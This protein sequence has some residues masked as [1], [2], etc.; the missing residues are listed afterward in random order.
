MADLKSPFRLQLALQGGGAKIVALVAAMKAI[1]DL[2]TDGVIKVTRIAGTSAGA[3]VGALYAARVSMGVV[4]AH[5]ENIDSDKLI[6]KLGK[7]KMFWRF[8]KGKAFWSTDG[9]RE[10]L[11]KLFQKSQTSVTTVG[12]LAKPPGIPMYITAT[13]IKNST[14]NISSDSAPIVNALLDS[15]ALPIVFRAVCSGGDSNILDGGICENLPSDLLQKHIS[16]D[17]PILGFSFKPKPGHTPQNPLEFCKAL[18]DAAINNSM[19]RAKQSLGSSVFNIDTDID[20]F[21]FERALSDGLKAE[22]ENIFLKTKIFIRNFTEQ[23]SKAVMDSTVI[24][25]QKTVEPRFSTISINEAQSTI[26][27][28][29]TDLLETLSSGISGV[30]VLVHDKESVLEWY[31]NLLGMLHDLYSKRQKDVYAAWL[32]PAD[33][34]RP[35]RLKLFRS[36]NLKPDYKHY[37]Y[38]LGEGF[39]GKVWETHTAAAT[40]I[41]KHHPWWVFRKDC[42]NISYICAP[43]GGADGSGGVLAIGSDIGFDIEDSDIVIMKLFASVLGLVVAKEK[44]KLD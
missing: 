40:S 44:N 21:D 24:Q 32:R 31:D 12:D 6:P 38:R 20:T 36:C 1:E 8:L 42:E 19:A 30:D 33:D 18:L 37:E 14:L 4:K 2:E 35:R 28:Y 16:T 3:I 17:G 13:D 27:S 26:L 29:L 34:T 7:W 9:I 11:L 43:V 41:A 25:K 5:L 10:E 15:C 23:Y 39:A 22:Y